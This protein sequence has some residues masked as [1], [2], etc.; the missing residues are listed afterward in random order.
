MNEAAPNAAVADAA[1]LKSQ[2]PAS[3]PEVGRVTVSLLAS[4]PV[5]SAHVMLCPVS[6]A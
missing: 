2:V 6:D 5:A 3:P 4:T 1:T